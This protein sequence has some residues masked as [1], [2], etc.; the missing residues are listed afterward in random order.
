[1]K[2]SRRTRRFL[3]ISFRVITG[4]EPINNGKIRKEN[5][6]FLFKRTPCFK[7]DCATEYDRC[8]IVFGDHDKA[9]VTA[10]ELLTT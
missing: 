4:H 10:Y 1:M 5:I 2:L 8:F 6:E 3:H 7:D 9:K